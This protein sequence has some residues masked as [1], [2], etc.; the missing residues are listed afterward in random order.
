YL[1]E[2]EHEPVRKTIKKKKA[3]DTR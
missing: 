2:L 1:E 3:K